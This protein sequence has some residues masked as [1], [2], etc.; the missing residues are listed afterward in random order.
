M[1]IFDL[2]QPATSISKWVGGKTE[3]TL[4]AAEKKFVH[5]D[6]WRQVS[7]NSRHSTRATCPTAQQIWKATQLASELQQPNAQPS[8]ES[9]KKLH[10]I[11]AVA[12]RLAHEGRQQKAALKRS[13][14]ARQRARDDDRLDVAL[15]AVLQARREARA[16]RTAAKILC[17]ARRVKIERKQKEKWRQRRNRDFQQ[18]SKG[19][20]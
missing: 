10:Q 6:D 9:S 11:A 18:A 17:E 1:Q 13:K 19:K 8:Q 20:V 4:T 7:P 3:L 16:K 5:E 12:R 14:Q 2:G 15:P